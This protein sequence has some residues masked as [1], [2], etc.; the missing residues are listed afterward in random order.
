MPWLASSMGE[1]GPLRE[2][3]WNHVCSFAR[4]Q[5]CCCCCCCCC[6]GCSAG[7]GGACCCASHS[8]AARWA[9]AHSRAALIWAGN[10][11]ALL[12]ARLLDGFRFASLAPALAPLDAHR[13]TVR[14]EICFN[15]TILR[16]LSFGLDLHW[17]QQCSQQQQAR[18]H[19]QQHIRHQSQ[20]QP[21]PTA[22]AAGISGPPLPGSKGDDAR[23][24]GQTV[25]ATDPAR[26][27]QRTPLASTADYSATA[28][29]AYC[30]FPPLY[31]AGPIIT[32]QD[33]AWQLRQQQRTPAREVCGAGAS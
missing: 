4:S 9:A 27:R 12:A 10:L 7:V 14:W 13:G 22:A 25:A 11:G 1:G 3:S 6:D 21:S 8:S 28:C 5:I 24:Q 26:W 32:F 29:L 15:L 30:L 33:F 17:Q 31:L 19:Q 23:R 18:H 16:S 20:Q 2:T